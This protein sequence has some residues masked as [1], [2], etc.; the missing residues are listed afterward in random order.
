MAVGEALR[1]RDVKNEHQAVLGGVLVECV[2]GVGVVKNHQVALAV[3]LQLVIH[4]QAA[5]PW[6]WGQLIQNRLVVSVGQR[7]SRNIRRIGIK[8]R[9]F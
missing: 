3:V 7:C 6:R 8:L 1:S 5:C 4:N 9:H 2:V